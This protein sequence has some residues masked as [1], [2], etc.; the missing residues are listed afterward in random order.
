MSFILNNWQEILNPAPWSARCL[1]RG[2]SDGNYMYICGGYTTGVVKL[3]D[4]WRSSDGSNWELLVEHAPWS[5]RSGHGFIYYNNKFWVMGGS[6]QIGTFLRDVWSSDDAI[7]WVQVTAGAAWSTRHEFGLCVFNNKMFISGGFAGGALRSDVYSSSNGLNWTLECANIAGGWTGPREHASAEFKGELMM[8]GGAYSGGIK[9]IVFSSA[10]GAVFVND[11]NA[12]WSARIEHQAVIDD[13]KNNLAIIGGRLVSPSY[14]DIWQTSDG[15]NFTQIVQAAPFSVRSDFALINHNRRAYLTGGITGVTGIVL[16]DV[17]V[18]DTEL[19]ADFTGTPT[20]V[21]LGEEVTF[22]NL[23]SDDTLYCMWNFGYGAAYAMTSGLD[24][25]SHK[26]TQ[27]GVFT[28][29]LSAINSDGDINTKARTLYI[30]V[31]PLTLDFVGAPR[32][33]PAALKVDFRAALS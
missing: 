8:Y 7:N 3:N 32:T 19:Y 26:F 5:A 11:G 1:H 31:L 4:V 13:A 28:I 27:V 21:M 17:W 23:S 29:T 20:T 30:T 9:N 25:V 24:G 12:A 22:T 10:T 15:L 33:G 14:N 2:V 16:G 6:N 18:S